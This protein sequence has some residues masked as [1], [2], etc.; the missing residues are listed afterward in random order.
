MKKARILSES[1]PLRTELGGMRELGVFSVSLSRMHLVLRQIQTA[2][3]GRG[4]RTLG[5]VVQAMAYRGKPQGS[6]HERT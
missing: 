5:A 3:A 4:E 2:L 6:A 1:G